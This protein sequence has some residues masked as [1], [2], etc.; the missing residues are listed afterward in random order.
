PPH[1]TRF[2]Y[3]TL[4]RSMKVAVDEITGVE[5]PDAKAVSKTAAGAV[6]R[7]SGLTVH[8]HS[9]KSSA[10]D[11]INVIGMTV[12]E[13]TDRL[14]KFLDDRSEEHTSELQSLRHL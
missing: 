6:P 5:S 13:A 7:L 1:S 9:R 14:D 8:A 2:P 4:F 3:T 11:E 12:E 10:A